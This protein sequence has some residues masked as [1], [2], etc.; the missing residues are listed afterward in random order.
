[1][2]NMIPSDQTPDDP[3]EL[4]FYQTEDGESRIQ[5]RLHEGTVW[6]T[7]KL[8]ADLYQVSIPTVNGH[9][10][11]IYDDGEAA[12]EATIRKFR[13]VQT[14]GE[15]EVSRLVDHYR[16]EAIL[17]VGY[18]VRSRRGVQ[19]RRWATTQLEELLV[20]GFVMDDERLKEGRHL[21]TDY[22]DELL[23][24]IR[25][26]RASEKRFYQKI[27]DLYKLALDYDKDA[28]ET[29][30]FFQTVQNKMHWAITG[31]TAA[32]IIKDRAD[33]NQPNMGLTSWKG[34]KVRKSDVVVAKNYLTQTEIDELNRIV[35]MYLDYAEDQA[36]K[37]QPL[38]MADWRKK[39]DAFLQF[40]DRNVLK[41]AGKVKMDVAKQLAE[42][43][44]E[45][46]NTRRLAQEAADE[47]DADVEELR[48]RIESQE[49][50]QEGADQ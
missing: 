26:I 33:S 9:L 32:E 34:A 1:M 31:K 13:I 43:Q 28:E 44:Y 24:R 19:F 39:L 6:L 11:S 15:R 3:G 46:F 40:N 12:P 10:Q 30:L 17:A 27:R 20:K 42:D 5:L 48:R 36:R 49:D 35:V 29:Q 47:L 8:I 21:G 45:R 38:Y 22:F 4:L 2:S 18:R 23:E 50:D 25:D 41:H 14:E 37:R 16:L 7:Q